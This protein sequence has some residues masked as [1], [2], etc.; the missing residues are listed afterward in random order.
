MTVAAATIVVCVVLYRGILL[1]S[2]PLWRYMPLPFF[3]PYDMVSARM[4]HSL[5]RNSFLSL[6]A[7]LSSLCMGVLAAV[8]VTND[9]CRQFLTRCAAEQHSICMRQCLDQHFHYTA[10]MCSCSLQRNQGPLMGW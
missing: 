9:A 3:R 4:M 2:A 7:S 1:L 10:A 5:A 6:G 8:M